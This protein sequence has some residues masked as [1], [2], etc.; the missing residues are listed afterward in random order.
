MCEILKWRSLLILNVC[1]EKVLFQKP[2]K[3]APNRLYVE[4]RNKVPEECAQLPVLFLVREWIFFQIREQRNGNHLVLLS[5]E[6]KYDALLVEFDEKPVNAMEL[7]IN[8]D[9]V[10]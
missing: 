4:D 8:I 7:G 1:L 3:L 9:F 6:R 2:I 10:F 5:C